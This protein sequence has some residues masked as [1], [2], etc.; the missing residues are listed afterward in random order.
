MK[1]MKP[2]VTLSLVL[3]LVTTAVAAPKLSALRFGGVYQGGAAPGINANDD[4][5]MDAW[6]KWDGPAGT[7][8]GVQTAI[9]NGHSACTGFGITILDSDGR[10]GILIGGNA[11]VFTS[12]QLVP[13]SWQNVRAARI[14]GVLMMLVGGDSYPIANV[15]PNPLNSCGTP[16]FLIGAGSGVSDGGWATDPFNGSIDRVRVNVIGSTPEQNLT[17]FHVDEGV[18]STTTS[19]HGAV[20][21]LIGTPQWVPGK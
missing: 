17:F 15:T 14:G 11:I 20:M 8:S 9:Y 4:I 1:N 12:A 7:A 6:L 5:W 10:V 3:I 21:N 2:L 18:G 19:T 13:G 16:R